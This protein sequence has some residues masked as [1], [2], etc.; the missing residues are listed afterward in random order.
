MTDM[1]PFERSGL[2]IGPFRF[3]FVASLPSPSLAEH[4]PEAYNAALRE[5]PRVC[6]L[7]SC[8]HCGMPLMHNFICQSA[9]GKKFAVGSDCVFKVADKSLQDEVRIT[10]LR[11]AREARRAKAETERAARRAQW[12]IDNADRL[13]AEAKA[14]MIA[15]VEAATKRAAVTARW[16]FMLPI[17]DRQSG[18][19]C[20][21]MLEGIRNG[22]APQGRAITIL[23]EIFAKRAGRAG[24]KAYEAA[25]VEFDKFITTED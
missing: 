9:D 20:A 25:L 7:G 17:L 19:F 3:L 18:P 12:L 15:E 21:S 8:A 6:P 16:S 22:H 5:L 10:V 13:A 1:H 4:N 23:A 14:K 2:G 11:R 24:S